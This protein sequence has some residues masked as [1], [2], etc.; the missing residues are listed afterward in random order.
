MR[1]AEAS[2]RAVRRAKQRY[3][4]TKGKWTMDTGEREYRPMSSATRTKSLDQIL[5]VYLSYLP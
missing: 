1:R 3:L 4:G 5:S 2:D